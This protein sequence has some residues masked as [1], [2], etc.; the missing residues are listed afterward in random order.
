MPFVSIR[1]G[2]DGDKDPLREKYPDYLIQWR[3][4]LWNS[5]RH[6]ELLI[7]SFIG[8]Y[9]TA[10]GVIL[11]AGHQYISPLTELLAVS[12]LSLL[13]IHVILDANVWNARN[14]FT[15]SRI[16]KLFISRDAGIVI[17]EHYLAPRFLFT[18]SI[19]THLVFVTGVLLLFHIRYTWRYLHSPCCAITSAGLLGELVF[20]T[21]TE[22]SL[23]LLLPWIGSRY[24]ATYFSF[25]RGFG[26]DTDGSALA[27]ATLQDENRA[28]L[29]D[30]TWLVAS[31][32]TSVTAIAFDVALIASLQK[33]V[34]VLG[35]C[36]LLVTAV[37]VNILRQCRIWVRDPRDDAAQEFHRINRLLL[38]GSV[39][40]LLAYAALNY[41]MLANAWAALTPLL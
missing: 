13:G 33:N 17:P 2:D 28:R 3:L 30:P 26:R 6:K 8:F 19:T 22:L 12:L 7:W 34:L 10:N 11:G 27:P 16:E 32:G 14:L 23:W 1:L 5:I 15:V 24:R 9:A 29:S 31:I 20:A 35:S 39:L 18:S 25:R 38:A 40:I 36:I 37:G 41:H 21:A 4:S